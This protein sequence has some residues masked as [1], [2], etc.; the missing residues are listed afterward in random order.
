VTELL[1]ADERT[2]IPGPWTWRRPAPAR[3][4]P[5]PQSPGP[6]PRSRPGNDED[7]DRAS[8]LPNEVAPAAVRPR[9]GPRPALAGDALQHAI[10]QAWAAF[11]RSRRGKP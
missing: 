9:A 4:R 6:P 1:Q 2:V 7:R 8:P 10:D 11:E 5:R 3:A